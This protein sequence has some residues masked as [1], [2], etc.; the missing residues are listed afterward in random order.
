LAT[1]IQNSSPFQK[2]AQFKVGDKVCDG[3]LI[4]VANQEA[5]RSGDGGVSYPRRLVAWSPN[6]EGEICYRGDMA[7]ERQA[8]TVR[9]AR[10]QLKWIKDQAF[11]RRCTQQDVIEAALV[12]A[13]APKDGE[14]S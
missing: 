11:D 6:L 3:D 1:K 7:E 2:K 5:T 14:G 12:A 13:G 10:S 9:L 4:L 8:T